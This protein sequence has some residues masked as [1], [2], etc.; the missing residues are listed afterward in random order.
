MEILRKIQPL[1]G[2]GRYVFPSRL[3]GERP[4]PANAI[5]SA[6]RWLG[7]ARVEM[8]AQGFRAMA[9]TSLNERGWN[10][11]LVELQ[12]AHSVRNKVRAAY[13]RAWRLAE[14][15]TMMQA[16]ADYLDLLRGAAQLGR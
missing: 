5:N 2:S 12:L 1:K 11:D 15:R 7:Y 8:T 3:S 4:M 16:W 14:P 6:L 9:S 13:N 10:P